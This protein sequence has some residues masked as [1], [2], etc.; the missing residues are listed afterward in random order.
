M[1]MKKN[2]LKKNCFNAFP[3]LWN[4]VDNLYESVFIVFIL[5]PGVFYNFA[6][7]FSQF[8]RKLCFLVKRKCTC[9]NIILLF[10]FC[11]IHFHECMS[12]QTTRKRRKKRTRLSCNSRPDY[13]AQLI[14]SFSVSYYLH[15]LF[16]LLSPFVENWFLILD[17]DKQHQ[18]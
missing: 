15:F 16:S 10:S 9:C 2:K 5:L 14:Y 12:T 4:I 1:T 11:L 3:W 17:I 7:N 18:W 6:C 8:Q 13:N